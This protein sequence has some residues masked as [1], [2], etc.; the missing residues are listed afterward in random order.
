[1]MPFASNARSLC[2]AGALCVAPLAATAE[3]SPALEEL[4]DALGLPQVVAVM[5]AEGVDYGAELEAQLFPG[6]GGPSWSA[7]VA[8]IY[9]ADLMEASVLERLAEEMDDTDLD[10]L[11]DF[12]TSDRGRRIVGFEVSARQALMDED[13]EAAAK[14]AYAQ[15]R[16][17]DDDRL[18]LLDAFT[19]ANDLIEF[20]VM[21]AMNSSFAFSLGLIDGRAFD[22]DLTQEQALTDVWAQEDEI[23]A[24]TEE[25]VYA[26]L[27]MAYKPLEDADLEAYVA[28]SHTPEGRAM[29]RALFAAFDAMYVD[30]SRQLGL[31]AARFLVGED[32]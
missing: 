26:F 9:S 28:L 23:R 16:R 20:N 6:R 18:A 27:S 10:P 24:D 12:F 14:E 13:I 30:I 4:S 19:E 31:A 29:N 3:V 15:M 22:G 2:L 25:W 7:V 5:A 11:L 21:G 1:M 17:Q 32:I 8:R